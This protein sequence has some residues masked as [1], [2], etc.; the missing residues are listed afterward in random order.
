MII[1]INNHALGCFWSKQEADEGGEKT[2]APLLCCF[3][4]PAKKQRCRW[5][6]YLLSYLSLDR[7]HCPCPALRDEKQEWA[8]VWQPVWDTQIVF[9]ALPQISYVLLIKLFILSSQPWFW[10][11]G[12]NKAL[13]PHGKYNKVW[14]KAGVCFGGKEGKKWGCK[15]TQVFAIYWFQLLSVEKTAGITLCRSVVLVA[16][17]IFHFNDLWCWWWFVRP[18]FFKLCWIILKVSPCRLLTVYPVPWSGPYTM[19]ICTFVLGRAGFNP[20]FEK[21]HMVLQAQDWTQGS[22]WR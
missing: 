14:V 13:I 9:L 16:I 10:C 20:M 8:T 2:A 22:S 21:S 17:T 11:K 1:I 18:F 3:S 7:I 12:I 5:Y 19:E 4:P 15:T 6:C